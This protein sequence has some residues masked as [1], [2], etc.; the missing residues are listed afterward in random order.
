[1]TSSA[2]PPAP[3]T[4]FIITAKSVLFMP[5]RG[6]FQTP[7]SSV[8]S[9]AEKASSGGSEAVPVAALFN[10]LGMPGGVSLEGG[11]MVRM[12]RRRKP[13]LCAAELEVLEDPADKA[14]TASA[15]ASSSLLG[16]KMKFAP[17]EMTS[18]V[19][20]GRSSRPPFALRG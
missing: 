15:T 12:A 8:P 16:S 14:I 19:I 13:L 5:P 4:A 11:S 17:T 9:R 20:G 1:M 2:A 7:S 18:S 6:G 3:M 10:E